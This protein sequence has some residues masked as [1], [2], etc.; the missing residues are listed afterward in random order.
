MEEELFNKEE[1]YVYLTIPVQWVCVY[2]KLLAYMADFGKTIIDDCSSICSN[3]SKNIITCW[4]LFQSAVAC[5]NL[6][7]YKQANFF[8]DY[9]QKQIELIY[10]GTDEEVYNETRPIRVDETNGQLQVVASCNDTIQFNVSL[11][12]G[13][14]YEKVYSDKSRNYRVDEENGKLT[15]D[16]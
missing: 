16:E 7:M 14:L 6:K 2:H 15:I 3:G 12:D 8:I 11:E 5:Y 9:I 13:G 1:E 10:K 4:N